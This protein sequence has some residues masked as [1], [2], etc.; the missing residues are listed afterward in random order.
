M[1]GLAEK[2]FGCEQMAKM[3]K[4]IGAGKSDLFDVLACVA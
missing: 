2:G 1:Y 4:I 3:Q